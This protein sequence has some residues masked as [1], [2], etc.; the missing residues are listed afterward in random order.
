MFA[1]VFHLCRIKKKPYS[2]FTDSHKQHADT[3]LDDITKVVIIAALI[4]VYVIRLPGIGPKQLGSSPAAKSKQQRGVLEQKN[5][6]LITFITEGESDRMGRFQ[7]LVRWE[8]KHKQSLCSLQQPEQLSVVLVTLSLR[9]QTV[10][11]VN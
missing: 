3:I 1:I 6:E 11:L 7:N 10:Q 8:L 5:W 9:H 4:S 2:Q